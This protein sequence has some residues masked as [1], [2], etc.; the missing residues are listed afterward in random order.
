MNKIEA[1]LLDRLVNK[2]ISKEG[3]PYRAILQWSGIISWLSLLTVFVVKLTLQYHR[4]FFAIFIEA[5]LPL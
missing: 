5:I 3:V 1:E 2:A 4:D